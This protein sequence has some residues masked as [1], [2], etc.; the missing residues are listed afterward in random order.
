MIKLIIPFS[1]ENLKQIPSDLIIGKDIG[2][3]GNLFNINK[4]SKNEDIKSIDNQLALVNKKFPRALKSLHF[5]TENANYLLDTEIKKKLYKFIDIA[6]RFK[7]PII[8]IHSNFIQSLDEFNIN[9]LKSIRSKFIKFYQSLDKYALGKKVTICVENMPIIGSKGLDYDSIFVFP[10][11]FENLKFGN[12]KINWD[13]CHWSHTYC[14]LQQLSNF[15]PKIKSEKVPFD[16]FLDLKN[17][18][19]YFH[20]GSFSG[21]A[22]PYSRSERKEGIIPSDG[23]MDKNLLIQSLRKI[24]S[25]KKDFGLAMEIREKNYNDRL[26]LRKTIKWFEENIF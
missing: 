19:E 5:P 26:E 2:L 16:A 11:D 1:L 21:M 6:S 25:F 23:F 12:I 24:H 18:I 13:L 22:Y 17:Y 8:I 10:E 20:F 9:T 7:V 15:S 3:E 14:T 4:L